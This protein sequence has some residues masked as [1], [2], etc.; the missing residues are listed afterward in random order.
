[1]LSSSLL[2]INDVMIIDIL[3]INI[4]E[5]LVP[6][7]VCMNISATSAVL[8]TWSRLKHGRRRDSKEIVSIERAP[9]DET[10]DNWEEVLV[11]QEIRNQ[12]YV[13]PGEDADQFNYRIKIHKDDMCCRW[14]TADKREGKVVM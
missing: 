13:V 9:I 1:M 2:F 8:L 4:S 6:E 10:L 11:A 14:I 5:C 12:K 3:I 7:D